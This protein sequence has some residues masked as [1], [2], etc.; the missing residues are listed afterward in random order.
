MDDDGF[1]GVH[2]RKLRGYIRT[3]HEC[4]SLYSRCDLLKQVQPFSTNCRFEILESR[5][6][7]TRVPEVVNKATLEWIGYANEND[8]DGLGHLLQYGNSRIAPDDDY[9]RSERD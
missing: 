8:R 6:V 9:M 2:K 1:G 4:Y 7:S 5:N 3:V